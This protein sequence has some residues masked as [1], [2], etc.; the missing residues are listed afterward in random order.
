MTADRMGILVAEERGAVRDG[1]QHLVDTRRKMTLVGAA[2]GD[3]GGE[4]WLAK[5]S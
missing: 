3:V 4:T 5:S 2:G 1:M